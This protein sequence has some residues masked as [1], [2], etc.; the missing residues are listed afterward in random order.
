MREKYVKG[1]FALS[2]LLVSD[3]LQRFILKFNKK[4]HQSPR[5]SDSG[6]LSPGSR[7]P[8]PESCVLILDDAESN[9][10][11]ILKT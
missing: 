6:V 11:K 8:G 5:V 2:R 1:Y 4:V 10:S 3:L 9:C 7:V